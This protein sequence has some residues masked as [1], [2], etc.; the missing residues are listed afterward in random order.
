MRVSLFNND[1]FLNNYKKKT[2]NKYMV[3]LDNFE[4]QFKILMFWIY[5][6]LFITKKAGY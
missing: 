4:P 1:I 3:R 6:K 2:S 5:I